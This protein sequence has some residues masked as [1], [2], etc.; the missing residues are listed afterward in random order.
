MDYWKECIS[1]AFDDA[2]LSATDDQIGT[3]ASWA[4]GAHDNY[5]MAHGHDCIPNPLIEENERLK[6][7]LRNE[8]YKILCPDCRGSGSITIQG[9]C[10][11]GTSECSRCRGEG[12]YLP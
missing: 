5:S 10:H 7:K 8:R 3:V 4:E 2:K 12:R 11:S 6:H 9:P 1:E